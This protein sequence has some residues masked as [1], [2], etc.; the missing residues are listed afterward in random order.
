MHAMHRHTH[1]YAHICMHGIYTH[2][3][4]C[5]YNTYATHTHTQA[6]A[7]GHVGR[8]NIFSLLMSGV[9]QDESEFNFAVLLC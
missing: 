6:Q 2:A 4:I 1:T 9:Q 3:Q 5:L 7:Q 8:I